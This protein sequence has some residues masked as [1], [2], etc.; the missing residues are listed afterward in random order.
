MSSFSSIELNSIFG[1]LK[2]LWEDFETT[3]D[4]DLLKLFVNCLV[5]DFTDDGITKF[6]KFF[7]GLRGKF[8]DC[9][10]EVNLGNSFSIDVDI[11]LDDDNDNDEWIGDESGTDCWFE[12]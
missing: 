4:M 8:I 6:D 3:S 12:E 9:D 11:D 1:V 10:F 2:K 5:F 7:N